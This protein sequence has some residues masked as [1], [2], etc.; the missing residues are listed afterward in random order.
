MKTQKT[1]SIKIILIIFLTLA[2]AVS[3]L[4]LI[5]VNKVKANTTPQTQLVLPNNN[6]EYQN[7]TSPVDAYSD[8]EVTAILQDGKLIYYIN[9][10]YEIIE[11]DKL[12]QAKQVKKLDSQTLLLSS[13]AIIK[14]VNLN[15][16]ELPTLELNDTDVGGTFFDFNSKYLV[17]TAGT[18]AKTYT[19][20]GSNLASNIITNIAID[21]PIAINANDEIF[22]IKDNNLQKQKVGLNSSAT[23]LKQVSSS[24][25]IANNEYVYY[26]LG[27][28]IYKI[29][30]N[31]GDSVLLTKPNSEYDLGKIVNPVSISF[32]G[33]NLLITGD[34]AVQE[35]SVKEDNS[36]EF[37]GFAIAK[38][39]TAYNRISNSVKEIERE[40][41]TLATLDND[42]FTLTTV[43]ETFN[44]YDTSNFNKNIKAD[45]LKKNDIFP[46]SFALGETS[47]LFLYD[48]NNG[49]YKN[50]LTYLSSFDS[51]INGVEIV[52]AKNFTDIVYQSGKY[53]VLAHKNDNSS[54][55]FVSEEL[56]E[57]SFSLFAEATNLSA[58]QM[59][60]DVFGNV[61][62]YK[63][64]KIYA[65]NKSTKT[66]S[67]ISEGTIN[68]RKLQADLG[69][70]LF[71]LDDNNAIHAY[72]NKAWQTPISFA[73]NITANKINSFALDFDRQEVFMTYS[74]EELIVKTNALNNVSIDNL[75]ATSFV[76]TS[77]N[78]LDDL[79]TYTA[80]AGAN[81]YSVSKTDTGFKFN[82]LVDNITDY[83]FI[84]EIEN[85]GTKLFALAGQE[86][87]ILISSSQVKETTPQKQTEV[88]QTAFITTSV[89]GYYFPLITENSDYAL[90]D[91]QT[92][93]LSKEQ[94]IYPKHKITFLQ[95]DYYFAE[96][97]MG[98][99]T[100]MG[101]VPVDYTIE[102]LSQD[103]KWNNYALK[104]VN[105]TTVYLEKEMTNSIKELAKDTEIRLISIENGVAQILFS[106][107]NGYANGY[108]SAKAIQNGAKT[109]IR[110]ILIIL[111]VV[112]S[113]CGTATFFLLRKKK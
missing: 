8:D 63:S 2:L 90:L 40:K 68:V 108:I 11:S 74:G 46:D 76:T 44:S 87:L 112:T 95:K 26:L 83:A 52:N 24:S 107:E 93:R 16:K 51:Q 84:T 69:G 70:N 9:G 47:A 50:G 10:K 55:I 7:L 37:T 60:I 105:A 22:Y 85:N 101:Y 71:A 21:S 92:V 45:S 36:L 77:S 41:D 100:Y 28:D 73:S 58:S 34:N 111:A 110:N 12:I 62:L 53:Y 20:D 57:L 67:I 38:N 96:F 97:T 72:V 59:E 23:Q 31:G 109:A 17:T 3:A 106:T 79:K 81:V 48:S 61:Y 13:G 78:A 32:K 54:Q 14:R 98:E 35:F 65:L 43:A 18:T 91:G 42:Y 94:A 80:E 1:I 103:F 104:K 30:V 56:N 25:I 4:G 6:L 82:N 15:T 29:S 27:A 33:E 49:E 66:A 64:G 102:I 5:S 39:K 99:N 75:K 89:S 113:A 86:S 19:F 88:P